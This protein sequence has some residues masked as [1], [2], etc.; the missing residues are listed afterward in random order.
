MTMPGSVRRFRTGP[1]R[2]PGG[3]GV[4]VAFERR[5]AAEIRG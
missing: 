4:L 3:R 1:R 2:M 5:E